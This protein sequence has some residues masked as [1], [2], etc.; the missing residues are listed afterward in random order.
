MLGDVLYGVLTETLAGFYKKHNDVLLKEVAVLE[1][2]NLILL[3]KL[4]GYR[5]ERV[6][7][8]N[9]DS[10]NSMRLTELQEEKDTLQM[11]V[12]HLLDHGGDLV[13]HEV[14][15]ARDHVSR[16]YGYEHQFSQLDETSTMDFSDLD[17]M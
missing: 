16:V 10:Y 14:R 4:E 17:D 7:A 15:E 13:H 8:D 11:L 12:D 5:R 9:R 3:E 6:Y 1:A 2:K